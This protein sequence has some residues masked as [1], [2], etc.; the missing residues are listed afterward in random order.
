MVWSF[1]QIMFPMPPIGK[2][3]FA[4]L[5]ARYE[6]ALRGAP[7]QLCVVG[8][9]CCLLRY[10]AVYSES[11]FICTSSD[12]RRA[13]CRGCAVLAVHH[14]RALP[15][16]CSALCL[17]LYRRSGLLGSCMGPCRQAELMC[18]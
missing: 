1:L 3:I 6:L 12:A 13:G 11:T 7:L 9:P 18:A 16:A 14:L 5:G 17:C 10:C 4:L 15:P 8:F 2:S